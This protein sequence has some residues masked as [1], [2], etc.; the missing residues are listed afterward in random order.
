MRRVYATTIGIESAILV[1]QLIAYRLAASYLGREGFSEYALARRAISLLQPAVVLG[2]GIAI[3]RYMALSLGK[4]SRSNAS[5]QWAAGLLL[6]AS[7]VAISLGLLN[8]F[9]SSVAF[10]LFG[11]ARH[12]YLI[13]SVGLML[14]GLALHTACYGY[15]RG[16]LKM[17]SANALQFVNIGILPLVI[18]PFFGRTVSIFLT[19]LGTSMGLTSALALLATRF[20]APAGGDLLRHAKELLWY[21]LGRVPGDLSQTALLTS[22]AVIVAHLQG[23]RPAGLVAFGTSLLTMIA[24]LFVPIGTVLLPEASQMIGRGDLH[25]L[26]RR[27]LQIVKATVPPIALLSLLVEGFAKDG[28]RLFLGG[29]FAIQAGIVR[30]IVLGAVPYSIYWGLKAVID[31]SSTR[32]INSRNAL[33]ALAV[34]LS[35]STTVYFGLFGTIYVLYFFVASLYI[36]GGLTLLEAWKSCLAKSGNLSEMTAVTF[37][38]I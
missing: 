33:I 15:F 22:P 38:D 8:F 12:R 11:N 28:I 27:V 37:A 31:A 6:L 24:S 34:F 32:P 5:T 30:V 4:G 14:L 29:D 19:A 36:L 16:N 1:S 26:R 25:G 20:E 2:L 17:T 35:T 23:L 10:L 13:P 7:S 3:P 21:G 9:Q 18:F